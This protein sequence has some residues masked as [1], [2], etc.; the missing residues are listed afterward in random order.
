M[1]EE[2]QPYLRP[3]VEAAR[4][5]GAGFRSLLWASPQTQAARF[6]AFTRACDFH[7]RNVL[8]VGCGR[9]DLY[10]FLLDR[11]IRPAHYVG[12]E[13]VPEL[14]RAARAKGHKGCQIVEV[15]FIREPHRLLVG[16]DAIAISGALNTVDAA[17]FYTTLRTAFEAAAETLVFN[18]LGSPDLAAADY[19]TW[20]EPGDVLAFARTLASAPRFL[21]DYLPGDCTIAIDHHDH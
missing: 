15:D 4:R 5:H 9:A 3:Y 19:L 13:G 16:A 21:E 7:E 17:T 2:P 10:D 12:L 11:G 18:F 6:D 8:D 20:H 1:D 14:A